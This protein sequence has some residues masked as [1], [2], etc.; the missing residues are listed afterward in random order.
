[1]DGCPCFDYDLQIPSH[2]IFKILYIGYDIKPD[3]YY[4]AYKPIKL[5]CILFM[6]IEMKF[7]HCHSCVMFAMKSMS[8]CND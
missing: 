8:M 1:M 2:E 4:V 7:I 6:F 5:S 3:A